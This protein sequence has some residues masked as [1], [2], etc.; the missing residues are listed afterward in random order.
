LRHSIA[1]HVSRQAVVCAFM[2]AALGHLHECIQRSSMHSYGIRLIKI[3]MEYIRLCLYAFM[4]LG[5]HIEVR[6]HMHFLQVGVIE[7]LFEMW[8]GEITTYIQV[9]LCVRM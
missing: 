3:A 1:V 8:R 9:H 2:R 6:I 5:Q 4:R 7:S